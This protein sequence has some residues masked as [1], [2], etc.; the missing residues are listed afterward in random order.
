MSGSMASSQLPAM[1]RSHPSRFIR[2]TCSFFFLDPPF[3]NICS[4]FGGYFERRPLLCR[5]RVTWWSFYLRRV[6]MENWMDW[7]MVNWTLRG[8]WA[9]MMAYSLGD[10]KP[11]VLPLGCF[12]LNP[13]NKE[14]CLGRGYL[15]L[16]EGFMVRERKA[17]E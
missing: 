14:G 3:R 16:V 1:D 11:M 4:E 5:L 8:D 15:M 6:W 2:P 17:I 10:Q 7:I 12:L 9:G 13:D